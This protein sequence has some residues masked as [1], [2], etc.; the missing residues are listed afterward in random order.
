MGIKPDILVCRAGR[1]IPK[2]ERRKIA[3]FCNVR[4]EAVIP[5]LDVRSIYAVPCA[6]H[7]EG[8]D[9]EVCRHFQLDVPPPG[10]ASW[11]AVT[12]PIPHPDGAVTIGGNGMHV[13]LLDASNSLAESLAHRRIATSVTA[14]V[15]SLHSYIFEIT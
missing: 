11:D 8:L 9:D 7:E 5:A 15:S 1:E 4:E 13:S 12:Q 6:Y 10:V 3:L 2:D 14:H